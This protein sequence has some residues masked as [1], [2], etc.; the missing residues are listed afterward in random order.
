MYKSPAMCRKGCM[1]HL[2]C[3]TITIGVH[4]MKKWYQ[5]IRQ[6][7]GMVAVILVSER[8]LVAGLLS[9]DIC[10]KIH[11]VKICQSDCFNKEQNS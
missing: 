4:D 9:Q 2:Q 11:C 10:V 5:N 7:A 8:P 1:G 6:C 3:I